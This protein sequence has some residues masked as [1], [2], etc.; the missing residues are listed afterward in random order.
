MYIIN[1]FFCICTDLPPPQKFRLHV[2]FSSFY[3]IMVLGKCPRL[4]LF[5]CS[6]TETWTEGIGGQKPHTVQKVTYSKNDLIVSEY[7]D[8]WFSSELENVSTGDTITTSWINTSLLYYFMFLSHWLWMAK[9]NWSFHENLKFF[10]NDIPGNYQN[11]N[12]R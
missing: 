11:G 4:R 1:F 3:E 10:K 5:F 7:K 9:I 12:S 8:E 2:I 6:V